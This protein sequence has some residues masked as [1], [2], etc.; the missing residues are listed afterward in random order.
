M[1]INRF[2]YEGLESEELY[3]R[4]LD[5][6]VFP[7]VR[8]L[9]FAYGLKVVD[10]P[11][12]PANDPRSMS[13][14]TFD[15]YLL[16]NA[17]G[18]PIAR[19][20]ANPKGGED[21]KCLEFFYATVHYRKQRGQSEADKSTLRSTK[22]SS[23][24]A[25]IKREKVIPTIDQLHKNF[26]YEISRAAK[27]VFLNNL[28]ND[29]KNIELTVDE[30]HAALARLL[31]VSTYGDTLTLDLDKCKKQLDILDEAEK[32]KRDKRAQAVRF[33]DNPFYAIG[34]NPT[35][36]VLV[37]KMRHNKSA[38]LGGGFEIITPF[39]RYRS[40]DDCDEIKALM[41]MSKVA[42]ENSPHDKVGP[43]P[44]CDGYHEG[45]DMATYYSTR[46]DMYHFLWAFTPAG[47]A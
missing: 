15:S 33:F 4:L 27:G 14:G 8:E 29:R 18:F 38:P 17:Q 9:N 31:G 43:L 41:T 39:K 24:M 11:C 5:D 6:P 25:T 44:C 40:A 12:R 35:G 16:V 21:F 46:P 42:F 34:V 47:D 30:I 28:G 26:P 20:F 10:Y 36:Q 7:L 37:G 45:L 2:F 22:L 1:S 19:V 3:R 13:A 32:V 23:L